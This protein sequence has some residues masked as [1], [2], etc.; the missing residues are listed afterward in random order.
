MNK[1]VIGLI[2]AGGKG[3]RMKTDV[4]KP[5]VTIN[6]KPIIW[7]SFNLLNELGIDNQF[8]SIPDKDNE[9]FIEEI[10]KINPRAKCIPDNVPMRGNAAGL[11]SALPN[12]PAH[13]DHIL[14]LHPD[15]SCFVSVDTLSLALQKHLEQNLVSTF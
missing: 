15:S 5:F 4:P 14:I 1:N 9:F 3:T 6:D 2:I 11:I 13:I 10:N 12:I 8:V 7:Y